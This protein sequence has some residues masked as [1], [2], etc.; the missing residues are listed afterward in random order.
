MIVEEVKKF[1]NGTKIN[2]FDLILIAK[3]KKYNDIKEDLLLDDENCFWTKEKFDQFKKMIK[4]E[5]I[6]LAYY[7]ESGDWIWPKRKG[8]H[9]MYCEDD[10]LD[11]AIWFKNQELMNFFYDDDSP[12]YEVEIYF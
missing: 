6:G 4:D 9:R 10:G 12:F 7:E 1:L 2:Y 8:G 3:N 11:C 5:I